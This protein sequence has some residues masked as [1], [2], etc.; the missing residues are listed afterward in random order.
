MEVSLEYERARLIEYA[1][2]GRLPRERHKLENC[3][4][5][6]DIRE[7]KAA[8]VSDYPVEEGFLKRNFAKG[9]YSRPKCGLC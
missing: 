2:E 1:E 6:F 8:L 7:L 3:R 4:C 5:E 9:T